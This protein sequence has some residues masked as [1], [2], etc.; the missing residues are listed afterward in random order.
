MTL[1][2]R[3]WYLWHLILGLNHPCCT[4]KVLLSYVCC[5]NQRTLCMTW[6]V[7]IS[8]HAGR[9]SLI[10]FLNGFYYQWRHLIINWCNQDE[11]YVHVHCCRGCRMIHD[12]AG[13]FSILWNSNSYTVVW[14]NYKD[15]C[16]W[17]NCSCNKSISV[18]W[19]ISFFGG[20]IYYWPRFI[21]GGFESCPIGLEGEMTD[22]ER[23]PNLIRQKGR[24]RSKTKGKL[25]MIQSDLWSSSS[26]C[27]FS[28]CMLYTP[29][30]EFRNICSEAEL[31]IR[32]NGG[33]TASCIRS[34]QDHSKI[35]MEMDWVIL[36]V[37]LQNSIFL[38]LGCV[39]KS[40]SVV[41]L[42]SC[43]HGTIW[44]YQYLACMKHA[45]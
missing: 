10:V 44:W 32:P 43:V 23:T 7:L 9:D 16:A 3:G 39:K 37:S 41:Y 45:L 27:L 26:S 15:M 1:W 36:K 25:L 4:N 5:W 18:Q 40:F 20:I 24:F 22:S 35:L 19:N 31:W 2:R 28:V 34:I 8:M 29:Q 14:A 38:S 13:S 12:L 6:H 21:H 11:R 42:G 17:S 33:R 30:L